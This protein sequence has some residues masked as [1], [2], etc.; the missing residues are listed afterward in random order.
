[1]AT[2]AS[3]DWDVLRD[4]LAHLTANPAWI[5]DAAAAC[6]DAIHAALPELNTDAD[7]RSSTYAS[8]ES[9]LRLLADMVARGRPPSAAEPPPAT[10]DYAREL[11]R[12]GVSIDGLLRAYHI[13]HAT[14]F[15]IWV[16]GL[17]SHVTDP[18]AVARGIEEGATWTFEYVQA[19]TRDL[20]QR[21]AD[22]RERW[23]RSAAAL[24]IETIRA[25]ING[26]RLDATTASQRLRYDLDRDH[27][28]F[29][30]W[31]TEED[32]GAIHL[33][34]LEGL[35]SRLATDL[36]AASALVVPVGRQV[37][38]AWIGSRDGC[39]AVP[40]G[41]RIEDAPDGGTLAA[42]GRPGAGVD[43]FCRSHLEAMSARR[44]AQL[45]GRR[46]GMVTRF[47]DVTLMALTSVDQ[48]AA[49]DFVAAELGPL[50]AQDDDTRRLAAT[51]RAYLEE[52]SS[53]RRTAQ[54]LGVHE[55]TIANRLRAVE[56]LRGRPADERIA[57]TLVA[58]RLARLVAQD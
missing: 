57:E 50:A 6:T 13:G 54:R 38:A 39:P 21:Y 53:P 58:L 23:V 33:S 8:T 14:F 29:V 5:P 26:D 7:M 51:L 25:L 19:L 40:A 15:E 10:V 16:S 46:P 22:E 27:V 55:N 4:A 37:V 2:R 45:A 17:R 11:V 12:H 56:E 49:R 35:A 30:V 9:V 28:A 1:M 18:A 32:Q 41:L 36:G 20:I 47:A 52:R 34:A 44:V 42:F 3:A 31:M 48:R 24:R 43:G